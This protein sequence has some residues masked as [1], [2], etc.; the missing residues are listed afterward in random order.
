MIDFPTSKRCPA[1]EETKGAGCF[2]VRQNVP[3][4]LSGYCKLCVD[5]KAKA[6]ATANPEARRATVRRCDAKPENRVRRAARD[7]T[8]EAIAERQGWAERNR[9]KRREIV[10]R[11]QRAH[12]ETQRRKELNRRARKLGLFVEHV[13]PRTVYEM[14]G[15]RCGICG[16][17]IDGDFHVDHRRPLCAG[18]PHSYANCQPAH[19]VCNW[20][21]GGR[22]E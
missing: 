20:S 16:E 11:S 6:R 2:Y 12:P 7:A 15:G 3:R 22:S 13:D 18:G 14:H 5:R 9:A 10:M 4:R 8:P 17:F 19:P 1:C 21:K